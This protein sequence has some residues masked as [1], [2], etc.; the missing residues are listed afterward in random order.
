VSI[1]DNTEGLT[2]CILSAQLFFDGAIRCTQERVVERFSKHSRKKDELG[3]SVPGAARANR[4]GLR[5]TLLE[6][7]GSKDDTG[8]APKSAAAYCNALRRALV[9]AFES[10]LS[11]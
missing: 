11:F 5:R 1:A 7:Q 9:A 2:Y 10:G 6:D 3:R 8:R 4:R